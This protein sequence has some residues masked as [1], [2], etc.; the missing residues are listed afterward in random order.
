[1]QGMKNYIIVA[2]AIVSVFGATT[3]AQT[4]AAQS[5]AKGFQNAAIEEKEIT[6]NT[7]RTAIRETESYS[8]SVQYQL[9]GLEELAI[10]IT[11]FDDP[12]KKW[13]EASHHFQDSIKNFR[14]AQDLCDESHQLQLSR[15]GYDS[16]LTE[17]IVMRIGDGLRGN[18]Q[19]RLSSIFRGNLLRTINRV[20]GALAIVYIVFIG[21]KYVLAMG[22]DEK[23]GNYK[24][25]FAWL[26]LGL[27][28]ISIAEF[29][30]FELLDPSGGNDILSAETELKFMDK[31]RDIVRYFEYAAGA[32]MLINAILAGYHLIMSGEKDE[33]ISQE[34]SFLKSLLLGSGFILM[35]EV[36]VRVLSFRDAPER[37]TEILVSEV[38]GIVNFAL[39]FIAILAMAMLALASLYYVISFGDEDQTTRA[40]RMIKTSLIGV[41]ISSASYVLVRFLI[42]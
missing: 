8:D 1:M 28:M 26:I 23:M 27:A 24:T 37:T 14:I 10:G 11:L 35:A 19:S 3:L 34:K 2:L 17:N 25:Q 36:I 6:D 20:L 40:K 32:L 9:I 5:R 22:D 30:G 15:E 16:A 12:D 38:A 21:V 39:S 4:P 42:T 41:V 13:D 29:A 31:V 33:T 7:C 18:N